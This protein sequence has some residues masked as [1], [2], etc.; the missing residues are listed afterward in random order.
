MGRAEACGRPAPERDPL[1]DRDWLKG[2]GGY[3]SRQ[4]RILPA[5]RFNAGQKI[6]FRFAVVTGL[7]VAVS[8][9]LLYYPALLGPRAS[10]VL[11][12]A[13][14]VLAALLSAAVIVHVYMAVVVHPEGVRAMTTGAMDE[15]YL[16]EDHPLEAPAGVEE[17]AA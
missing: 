2:F 5:G 7:V 6:W 11:Y 8:G 1:Y 9:A 16:R 13:H 3:F 14:T 12:A 15:A 10:I 4:R 17:P